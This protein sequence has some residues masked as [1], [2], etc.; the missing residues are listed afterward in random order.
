MSHVIPRRHIGAG[1]S[2][3]GTRQAL[4]LEAYLGT[5]VG[6][7][8]VDEK[9]GVGGL[10]HFL[11][12]EP[13]S[14]SSS[15]QPEKYA[16]TGMP[17]L[18]KAAYDAGASPGKLKAT[19]A[20]GALVGPVNDLDIH[21]NIG[22]RTTD[23]VLHVLRQEGIPVVQ[24]ETG[25]FFTC[26]LS[27]NMF[28]WSCRIEPAFLDKPLAEGTFTPPSMEEFERLMDGL[29][30]VPQSALKVMQIVENKEDYDIRA[31]VEVIRKD[32]VI[33]ARTIKLANSVLFRG[34]RPIETLDHALMYLGV[35][36]LMKFVISA[37]M[38]GLFLQ[39]S[40]GYSLCKGGLYQHA[41]GTAVIAENL[42]ETT[43][44]VSKNL[45][46]TAGLLHDIGKVALDQFMGRV[47]PLIYR[48]LTAEGE[49]DFT[50]AERA[51][52]NID[53][54]EAG[55]RLAKKWRFPGSLSEVIRYHHE[56]EQ[57]RRYPELA[58]LVHLAD[59]LM[60]RFRVGLELDEMESPHL[61]A[62]L[63]VIGLSP[64]QFA[65]EVDRI[66]AHVFEAESAMGWLE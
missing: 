35:N 51:L 34:R 38:D 49:K 47:Y 57:A 12:P 62:R 63:K 66:P 31:L 13:P 53:H 42:A 30:P 59:L 16:R 44:V 23:R 33:S 11:L 56:P 27:L 61:G 22:G 4:V 25:G 58:H 46:Y 60:A 20:G 10:S 5:C 41:V 17:L 54:T 1:S 48:K 21:L 39:S 26:R 19:I 24:E 28:D 14:V 36:L 9:T 64:Q 18:L 37:A 15:F 43:G 3:V 65:V 50:R 7:A 2:F 32:Q 45:A 55:F 52:F 40:D 8:V 6:V 29:L